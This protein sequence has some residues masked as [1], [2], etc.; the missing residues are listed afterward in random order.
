MNPGDELPLDAARDR[1]AAALSGWAAT[2]PPDTLPVAQAAGRVLAQDA[3][4]PLD[5]PPHDNAA[6][7]G[8]ALRAADLP[9]QGTRRLPVVGTVLAGAAAVS[10]AP[11]Q[12]VRIATG[13]RL[14]AGL[15]TVWPV[16]QAVTDTADDGTPHLCVAAG[17]LRPGQH[18]RQRGEDIARGQTVLRAGR[19]LHPADLGLLASLGQAQVRVHPRLRVALLSTGDELRA[20]G[21]PLPEGCI[22]DSNRTT[23][24][25]MLQRL[26]V[27]LTDLGVVPDQPDA[28]AAAYRAAAADADVLISSAGA[29]AGDADHTRRVLAALGEVE[30]WHL[31]LRPGRPFSFGRLHGGDGA[32]RGPV[33]FGLPGNPV[34]AAVAFLV[35]VRPALWTMA[36]LRG[37]PADAPVWT[38]RAAA[39]MA[40]RAGRTEFIRVTLSRDDQGT[41]WARPTG[42]QGSGLLHSLSAAHALARLPAGRGAVAEGEPVDVLPFDAWG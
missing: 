14:P 41:T 32:T 6:M 27:V 8:F 18:R 1:I 17:A 16:E 12:A 15:D 11:G 24:A 39:P 31:A 40:H 30:S 42:A 22:Y 9:D 29:S 19:R 25:A 3:V 28:L 5:V 26:P 13:A 37:E 20:P 7:D 21:E 23:L 10:P 36:G 4:S 34:A 35:L 38:A 33:V 2:D